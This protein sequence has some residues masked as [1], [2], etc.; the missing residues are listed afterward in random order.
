MK[1]KIRT[2]VLQN[3]SKKIF[4]SSVSHLVTTSD[5]SW[6]AK[7]LT[8]YEKPL[9]RY[10]AWLLNERERARDVVQEVFLRLCKVSYERVGDHVAEWLFTVCRNLCLDIR[11]SD[12]RQRRL[13]ETQV[14]RVSDIVA[15]YAREP[16][17]RL[18]L[19]RQIL[20][21]IDTLPANQRELMYLKFH[22]GFT[23]KEISKLTGLSIGNIGFLIHTGMH[24]IREQ[25]EAGES[26]VRSQL[27]GR[28]E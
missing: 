18:Q 22:E 15:E 27:S 14:I 19:L 17:E 9:L 6:I 21:M 23:Y 1:W 20:S 2:V 10:A 13:D 12:C 24:T 11:E 8:Q 4:C 5:K 16:V 28:S 7:A 26:R 25:V 3:F